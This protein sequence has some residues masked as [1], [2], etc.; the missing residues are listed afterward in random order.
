MVKTIQIKIFDITRR[1]V[2]HGFANS[3]SSSVNL[4]TEFNRI[5]G[6]EMTPSEYSKFIC[7]TFLFI[8]SFEDRTMSYEK[9]AKYYGKMPVEV[10]S[11]AR[12]NFKE[13]RHGIIAPYMAVVDFASNTLY[14]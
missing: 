11:G 10:S 9:F 6:E 13:M 12:L 3:F 2:G 1:F 4:G 7:H 8:D 14:R 5:S